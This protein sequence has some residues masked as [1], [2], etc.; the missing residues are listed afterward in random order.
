MKKQ[1]KL[2]IGFLFGFGMFFMSNTV[3][4]INAEASN[5]ELVVMYK[6]DNVLFN[7]YQIASLSDNGTVN[8]ES[9][10]RN[11][12]INLS[13]I[14][15]MDSNQQAALLQTLISYAENDLT[16]V[17]NQTSLTEEIP[18][19]LPGSNEGSSKKFAAKFTNLDQGIYLVTG[20]STETSEGIY[21]PTGSLVLV[22]RK[23]QPLILQVKF[24]ILMS[25]KTMN[26]NAFK[27]WKDDNHAN[28]PK[29]IILDLM[30]D[31]QVVESAELNDENQWQVIWNDLP[32]A[33]YQVIEREVP[34]G[35]Q[36]RIEKDGDNFRI[37]NS[38]KDKQEETTISNE[39]TVTT[40]SM[41]TTSST[42][43]LIP[44]TGQ[45]WWPIPVMMVISIA[46]YIIGSQK[47]DE[48]Q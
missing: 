12:P 46:F 44:S 45:I 3:P 13:D 29:S 42:D 22:D 5:L 4:I 15:T 25:E 7:L 1:L 6:F 34:I 39:T 30:A 48:M 23:N 40:E 26:I 32:V 8:I 33:D 16:L 38:L 21:Q 47:D 35:Y 17:P 2:I 31:K 43:N 24:S 10:F 28:R 18:I 20:E 14:A 36:V 19:T 37:E 11:Y 41:T 27:V 9:P